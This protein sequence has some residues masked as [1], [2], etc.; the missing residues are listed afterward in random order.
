MLRPASSL[1]LK[2]A[3]SPEALEEELEAEALLLLLLLLLLPEITK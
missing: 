1:P 2:A 3:R